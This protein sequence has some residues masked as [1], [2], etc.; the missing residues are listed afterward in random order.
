M[1]PALL[2]AIVA[3]ALP[4]QTPAPAASTPPS[5]TPLTSHQRWDQYWHDTFLS[6]GL[7]FAALSY[8]GGA[9]WDKRPPEW[10]QGFDGYS[11]RTADFVATSAIEYTVRDA[12]SA[13]LGYDPRYIR[14]ECKGAGRRLAHAFVWSFLTKNEQGHTRFNSPMLAGAYAGEMVPYF[15]Y[16]NRYSPLKDG[17]RTGSQEVGI[18][19]GLNIFREFTPELRRLVHPGSNP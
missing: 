13:A 3:V 2:L 8:A 14:C 16:P 19:V 15:W 5:Y 12:T 17:Y 4:A 9:Q 1:R 11:K 18:T 10:G 7:Y 6:P